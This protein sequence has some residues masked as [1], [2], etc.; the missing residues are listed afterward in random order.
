V[1][2]EGLS[3]RKIPMTPSGIEPATFQLVAQ[4]L[5]SCAKE[6]FNSIYP[7]DHMSGKY[8]YQ[9]HCNAKA[10]LHIRPFMS[11]KTIFVSQSVC[12][13]LNKLYSLFQTANFPYDIP[14][15]SSV[16]LRVIGITSWFAALET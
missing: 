13:S 11:L 8:T 5:T 4:C 9:T 7:Y 3:Q 12:F 2:L 16:F 15:F 14:G 6:R 10:L 1:R